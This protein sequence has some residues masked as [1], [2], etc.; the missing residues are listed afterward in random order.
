MKA[1]CPNSPEHKEFVTTAHIVQD[2]V[3]N[4]KGDFLQVVTECVETT[5]QPDPDNI[6]SCRECG[7][8]AIF[9]K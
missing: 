2:W 5:H 1:R 8:E 3:V 7:A 4:E 6:W 9:E